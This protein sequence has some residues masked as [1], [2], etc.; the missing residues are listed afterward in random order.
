MVHCEVKSY[1]SLRGQIVREQKRI[2][3]RTRC[4]KSDLAANDV[5]FLVEISDFSS[6]EYC[7]E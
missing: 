7:S 6:G 5:I 1:G 4:C 2:D 3:Q